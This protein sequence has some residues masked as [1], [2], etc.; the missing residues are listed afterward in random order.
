M[1]SPAARQFSLGD[2]YFLPG[3]LLFPNPSAGPL[4]DVLT[5]K[6]CF[7]AGRLVLGQFCFWASYQ[8]SLLVCLLSL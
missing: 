8:I 5:L 7:G 1:P 4:R 2:A 3:G 6:A